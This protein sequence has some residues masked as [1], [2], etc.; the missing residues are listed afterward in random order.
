MKKIVLGAIPPPLGGVSTYCSRRLEQLN[1][2]NIGFGFY[3]SR[4]IFEFLKFLT[5]CI[6]YNLLRKGYEVE[7]NVSN[8]FAL[9]SMLI[10]R[11]STKSIFIDHNGSRRLKNEFMGEVILYLFSKDAKKIHPVNDVLKNNYLSM[12]IS[13]NKINV[14]SP[15][16]K[17]TY[18]EMK[19]AIDSFP[20]DF[21][22]L[23]MSGGRNII[24]SSAW[25]TASN[26]NE[27]DLYGLLDVI[28][29]YKKLSGDYKTLNFVLMIGVITEDNFGTLVSEKLSEL[30]EISNIFIIIGGASQL[31]LLPK[32]K[33]FL[34]LTKTDGDSISVREALDMGAIVIATDVCPRPDGT[35]LIKNDSLD[36]VIS[37]IENKL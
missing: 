19:N 36:V 12:G 25:Q 21:N 29:I 17:P 5:I 37:E 20:K 8:R 4:S 23:T 13:E 15:Y 10:L 14:I 22:H 32:T 35:F 3:D 16:L 1:S 7:V 31:P 11:I 27:Y 30:S 33:I 2:L 18:Q 24:L 6:Y 9:L 26:E 28:E 34:R